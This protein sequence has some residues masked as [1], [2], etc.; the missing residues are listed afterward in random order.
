MNI[1]ESVTH[2][3]AMGENFCTLISFFKIN[4]RVV[5]LIG[6]F[7]LAIHVILLISFVTTILLLNTAR[8]MISKWVIVTAE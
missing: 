2:Q 3:A 5:I 8:K 1:N 7:T 6:S 4:N